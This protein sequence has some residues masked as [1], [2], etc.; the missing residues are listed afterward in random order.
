M[1]TVPVTLSARHGL[2]EAAGLH[3]VS[4]IQALQ[5]V[6]GEQ[7]QWSTL[8]SGRPLIAVIGDRL[9]TASNHAAHPVTGQ[10]QSLYQ[11]TLYAADG[12]SYP[13][14]MHLPDRLNT[15]Q[16]LQLK[17][18]AS[19]VEG[20]AAQVSWQTLSGSEALLSARLPL[21]ES[22]PLPANPAEAS[23]V[24]VSV[25]GKSLQQWLATQPATQTVATV[26]AQAVL[27]THPERPQLLAQELRQ[28]LTTSG[29]FYES[30]LKQA[31]LGLRPWQQ[32]LA[33]PQNRP[34]FSAPAMLAQQL[35]V[36]EQQRLQWQG[37]VWPGQRMQ[38]AVTER[39]SRP[40]PAAPVSTALFSNLSLQFP[41]LG[42]LSVRIT[43][44]DG[45]FSIRLQAAQ[46]DSCQRLQ[47]AR[48]PLA[49]RL[50]EAG[51]Q[52]DGLQVVQ[53]V[54]DDA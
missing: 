18:T 17:L 27:T 39:E 37:E 26:E 47:H 36:L 7:P 49:Q 21:L 15:S 53:A 12:A 46:V 2:S 32:L 5:A 25:T 38:W 52:V 44:L 42:E 3:G 34:D 9:T 4:P 45:R 31:T 14:I 29:L 51:L 20:Q 1:L 28:A 40:A 23:D 22:A 54:L 48:W 43:L 41:G 35:Q 33:E 8:F 10:G 30:H 13:V 6:S 16:M 50:Q 24:A 11:V 19:P